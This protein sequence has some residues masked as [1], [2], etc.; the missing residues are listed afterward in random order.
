MMTSLHP[1]PSGETAYQ[2][3]LKM[4]WDDTTLNIDLLGELV[5]CVNLNVVGVG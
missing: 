2:S 3:T 1:D 4:D 5:C